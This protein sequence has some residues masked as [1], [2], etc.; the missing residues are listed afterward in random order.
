MK[1]VHAAN[2]HIKRNGKQYF[3]SDTKIHQGLVQ[4]GHYVQPFPINDVARIHSP[5]GNRAL[6]KRAANRSLIETCLNVRPELLFLGHAQ[7]ITPKTLAKVRELLPDMR[8]A[9]WYCDPIW[10]GC[11]DQ[12]IDAKLPLLD[13]VFVTTGGPLL[14]RFAGPGRPAGYM[15]NLVEPAIECMKAFENKDYDHDLIFFGRDENAP[16]RRVYLEKLT[17]ALPTSVRVGMFGSL[18]Q[19]LIF[20]HEKDAVMARSRMALN[21]S[22]RN[23]VPLYSSD[24]LVQLVANGLATVTPSGPAVEPLFG[25]DEVV[26]ADTPEAAAKRITELVADEAACR[27]L[28]RRGWERAH[29]DYA[30]VKVCRY[31]VE[32]SMHGASAGAQ[33]PWADHVFD[34]G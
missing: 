25:P 9:L 8:V 22:R 6:G 18:G 5:L 26:Y 3:G 7:M 24:R 12:H 34:R 13:A 30:A 1:I 27:A 19:P 20:G 2:Y 10:P 16:E 32:V 14:E 17:A 33:V 4:N 23:D 11:D 15:P 28:A 21:L 29:R 31:M